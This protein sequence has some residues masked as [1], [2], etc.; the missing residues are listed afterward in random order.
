MSTILGEFLKGIDT[1]YFKEPEEEKP[2]QRSYISLGKIIKWIAVL[3]LG[4]GL[5]GA[6]LMAIWKEF[7]R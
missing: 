6:G 4:S 5:I 1:Q 3:M 2:V 7:K